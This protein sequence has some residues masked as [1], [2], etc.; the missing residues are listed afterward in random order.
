MKAQDKIAEHFMLAIS[1]EWQTI[2]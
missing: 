2:W 1:P